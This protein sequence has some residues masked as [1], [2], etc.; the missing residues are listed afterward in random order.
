MHQSYY[1]QRLE[2]WRVYRLEHG[3]KHRLVKSFRNRNEADA[4][5]RFLNRNTQ[6]QFTVA[7]DQLPPKHQNPLLAAT[8]NGQLINPM[9]TEINQ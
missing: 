3:I 5:V 1:H 4:L 6:F 9:N 7:F 8:K 2:P